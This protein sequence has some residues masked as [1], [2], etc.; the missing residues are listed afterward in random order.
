[1]LSR[2]GVEALPKL[3][4]LIMQELSSL[5]RAGAFLTNNDSAYFSVG[6]AQRADLAFVWSRTSGHWS[7][8]DL[9]FRVEPTKQ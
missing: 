8:L 5:H 9:D 7:A 3:K 4:P 6:P 1:M 2:A